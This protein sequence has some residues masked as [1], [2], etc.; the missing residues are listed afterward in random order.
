MEMKEFVD[1][2]NR[3]ASAMETFVAHADKAVPG[4][5]TAAATTTKAAA[6]TTKAA[7]TTK[8]A[9]KKGVTL[10]KLKEEFSGYIGISDKAARAERIPQVAAIA[11]HFGVSR[12]TE[13]D[14]DKWPEALHYLNLYKSGKTP[15]FTG[16]D[17]EGMS[18]DEGEEEASLV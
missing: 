12:I 1:A 3:L 16:L 14:E 11:E 6:T 13:A 10:E 8:A 18:E 9:G 17:D 4:K 15:N 7:A 2:M 5:A